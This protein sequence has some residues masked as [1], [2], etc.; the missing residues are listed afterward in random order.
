MERRVA[1]LRKAGTPVEFHKYRN[2][3]HGFGLGKGTSADGWIF[4][5]IRFWETSVRKEN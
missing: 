2:L 4:D 5:A 1:A 3:G